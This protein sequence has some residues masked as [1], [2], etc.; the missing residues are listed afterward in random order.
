MG[1]CCSRPIPPEEPTNL[2][3][4]LGSKAQNEV[5]KTYLSQLTGEEYLAK[6]KSKETVN[7]ILADFKTLPVNDLVYLDLRLYSMIKKINVNKANQW[8]I[9][10]SLLLETKYILE[11]NMMKLKEGSFADVQDKGFAFELLKLVFEIYH[12]VTF[13]LESHNN[14][15]AG[16]K[17][18]APSTEEDYVK[19]LTNKCKMSAEDV[20]NATQGDGF[21]NAKWDGRTDLDEEKETEVIKGEAKSYLNQFYG[22]IGQKQR[23]ENDA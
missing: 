2:L 10:H 13:M 17:W 15:N 19:V 6:L 18:W 20:K 4:N 22:N 23:Q 3:E 12:A 16:Q 8:G 5:L 21:M 1:T 7:K 9:G 11:E 14:V